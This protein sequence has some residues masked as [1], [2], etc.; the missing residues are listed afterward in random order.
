MAEVKSLTRK[1]LKPIFFRILGKK[2]YF[3]LQ[4]KAKIKDIEQRLVEEDEM[5]LLPHFVK[6]GDEVLDIGANYAYYTV[7]LADLVGEK[8]HVYAFEPI[9]FTF[10]VANEIVSGHYGLKNATVFHKGVGDETKQVVFEVPRQDFGAISA[11]QAHIT[12]RDNTV[13]GMERLYQ[14]KSHE[15]VTCDVVDIDSFLPD[16]DRLSFVKIDIEGAEL[17]ALKGM[18]RTL[19]QFLPVILIEIV[20]TFLNAF[21]I[22]EHELTD[23]FGT[24][25]YD[26]YLFDPQDGKLHRAGTPLIERNYLMIHPSKAGALTHLIA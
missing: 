18:R 22:G 21:G 7:R 14:F 24:L 16:L 11:G 1:I 5:V 2:G 25:G 19:E 15:K 8:G 4:V 10:N 3:R 17:H 6:A 12:G 9:P 26:F 13:S 20:P 23:F